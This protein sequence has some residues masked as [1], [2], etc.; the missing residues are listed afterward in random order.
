MGV[1]DE[2]CGLTSMPIFQGQPCV[3]VVLDHSVEAEGLRMGWTWTE[4]VVAIRKGAYDGYGDIA[5]NFGRPAEVCTILFH[6]EA[7]DAAIAFHGPLESEI[8][9]RRVKWSHSRT[10]EPPTLL[11]AL[12]MIDEFTKLLNVAQA[13]RRDVLAGLRFK[14][15]QDG[16]GAAPYK[17]VAKLARQ[18]MPTRKTETP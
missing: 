9:L 13:A 16:Q 2:T 11:P 15:M 18:F 17:F 1:W 8:P 5:G 12:P 3:C 10:G 14:G 6:R 7:W 4:Q